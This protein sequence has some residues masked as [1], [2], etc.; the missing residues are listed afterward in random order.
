M[1]P[2]DLQ[3]FIYREGIS[4]VKNR[5][6]RWPDRRVCVCVCVSDLRDGSV[7]KCKLSELD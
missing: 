4:Q 3:G 6:D 1:G 7:Q 5:T 2:L